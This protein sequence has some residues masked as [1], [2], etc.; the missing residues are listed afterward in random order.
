MT[1]GILCTTDFSVNSKH[2][3]KWAVSLAQQ[4]KAPLTILHTYRLIKSTN[5]E[6]VLIKRKMEEE[7]LQRFASLE[8]EC[9]KDKGITYNFKTEVGFVSDRVEEYSKKNPVS[10][11]VTDKNSTGNRESFDELL[12]HTKVP[13]VIVP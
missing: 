2:A 1:K 11:L 8:K 5:G 9:L 10:F 7:A 6:A 4:L 12:K 3:V 13:L